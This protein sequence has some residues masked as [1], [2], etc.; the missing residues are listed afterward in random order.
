MENLIAAAP[1]PRR[2]AEGGT[3]ADAAPSRRQSN[4]SRSPRRR[5]NYDDFPAE[6]EGGCPPASPSDPA[7]PSARSKERGGIVRRDVSSGLSRVIALEASSI[8]MVPVDEHVPVD[9]LFEISTSAAKVKQDVVP[10][11]KDQDGGRQE[12]VLSSV[13]QRRTVSFAPLPLPIKSAVSPS[14][15]LSS[16]QTKKGSVVSG[17]QTGTLISGNFVKSTEGNQ[18]LAS[19]ADTRKTR[20]AQRMFCFCFPF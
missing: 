20:G 4:R 6:A 7:G 14:Q 18:P 8:K 17:Q 3:A 1:A 5:T 15:L 10:S 9:D 19:G 2:K 16:N 13:G 12:R 11:A